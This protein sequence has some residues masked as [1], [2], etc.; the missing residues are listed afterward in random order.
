MA[1]DAPHDGGSPGMKG[2]PEYIPLPPRVRPFDLERYRPEAHALPPSTVHHFSGF[3]RSALAD[4]LLREP[5]S[6]LSHGASEGSTVARE[7]YMDLPDGVHQI[8]DEAG[9]GLFCMGL[10]Q[11]MASRTLLSALVER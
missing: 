11:L 6:H 7:W 1:D 8:I 9:F 10:S 2:E 3:A 5:A 4:L